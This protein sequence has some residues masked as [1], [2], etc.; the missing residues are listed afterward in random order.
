[1]LARRLPLLA[2]Q[3]HG[4]SGACKSACPGLSTW[5]RIRAD[6]SGTAAARENPMFIVGRD[7]PPRLAKLLCEKGLGPSRIIV[8]E[9]MGGPRERL[10][11][12]MAQAF[13][14]E[15]IDPLSIVAIEIAATAQSQ[16]LPVASGLAEFL[17]AETD[18]Q[19]TKREVRAVAL[20]SLAPRRGELLADVGAGSGSVAIEWLLCHPANRAIAIEDRGPIMQGGIFDYL[21]HHPAQLINLSGGF[22]GDYNQPLP[23]KIV[24]R[25]IPSGW[26][27]QNRLNCARMMLEYDIPRADV[28]QHIVSPAGVLERIWLCGPSKEGPEGPRPTTFLK[29]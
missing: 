17:V 19:L 7:D 6:H 27:Y 28:N 25:L 5:A 3:R 16:I 11:E 26:F 15:G 22:G 18:G 2:L 24:S 9:A 12:S 29:S 8:M 1:M 21:C 14:M 20:S 23:G 10:R 13:G 4:S